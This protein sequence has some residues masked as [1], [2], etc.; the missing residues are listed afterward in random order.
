MHDGAGV[1][2]VEGVAQVLHHARRVRFAE[3]HAL[4]DGVKQVS[5]L[6]Q[7]IS[8]TIIIIIPPKTEC[9]CLHGREIGLETVAHTILSPYAVYLYLYM[10]RY[11]CTITG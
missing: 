9:G 1:E 4:G 3:L 10:Y 11:G 2:V 6:Q 5:T 7:V 8:I